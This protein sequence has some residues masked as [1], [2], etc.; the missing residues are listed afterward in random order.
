LR[1]APLFGFGGR[2]FNQKIALREQIP[3]IFLG[4]TLADAVKT[5]HQILK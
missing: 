4:E 5:I 1:P 3:G 2:A